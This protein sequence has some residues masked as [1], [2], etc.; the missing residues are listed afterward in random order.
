MIKVG[1]QVITSIL[2]DRRGRQEKTS[3]DM[4]TKERH[5]GNVLALGMAP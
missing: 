5:R 3:N 1:P 2:K 4:T